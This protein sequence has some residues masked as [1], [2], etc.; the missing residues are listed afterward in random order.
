MT[1]CSLFLRLFACLRPLW[2]TLSFVWLPSAPLSFCHKKQT[3]ER[4]LRLFSFLCSHF[5]RLLSFFQFPALSAFCSSNFLLNLNQPMSKSSAVPDKKKC[6]I[7]GC[8]K[9][10]TESG[11]REHASSVHNV[12]EEP[13]RTFTGYAIPTLEGGK[14]VLRCLKCQRT[15]SNRRAFLKNHLHKLECLWCKF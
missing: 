6:G 3:K 10:V 14:N 12:I 9:F 11:M 15:C 2:Q 1:P 8:V 5:S 4:N 13:A 7:N